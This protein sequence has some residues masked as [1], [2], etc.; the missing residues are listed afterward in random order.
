MTTRFQRLALHAAYEQCSETEHGAQ[1][2][3]G[4]WYRPRHG[5][6][7]LDSLLAAMRC[8]SEREIEAKFAVN[9]YTP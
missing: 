6:D 2:V 8:K 5:K 4:Y 7:S 1:L 3:D 9:P